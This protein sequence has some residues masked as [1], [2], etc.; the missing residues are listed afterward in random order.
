MAD[1]L[2]VLFVTS[3][4]APFAKT[5]GLADVSAAL[6]RALHEAGHDVRVFLPFYARIDRRRY[7][8]EPVPELQRIELAIGGTAF[9]VSIHA[10]KLPGSSLR[11]HLVE[12]H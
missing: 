10:A 12:N 3:E 4:L 2:R 8:T 9:L 6:P 7:K 1:P 5:G 11:I